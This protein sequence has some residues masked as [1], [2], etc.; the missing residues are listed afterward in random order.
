MRLWQRALGLACSRG[1]VLSGQR[2]L[3]AACARGRVRSGPR[4]FGAACSRGSVFS[5]QHA[6]GVAS[7][8]AKCFQG[9]VFSERWAL[10]SFALVSLALRSLALGA[11]SSR[12]C[13]PAVRRARRVCFLGSL[14][15]GH[16]VLGVAFY[17]A[18]ACSRSSVL[19]MQCFRRRVL[20]GQRA[21]GA[22]CSRSSPCS[23]SS[24]L[25]EEGACGTACCRRT[26]PVD[27][28]G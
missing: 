20:V 28:S 6:L 15:A 17:L 8:R 21:V 9:N 5:M 4:A 2:A 19:P 12:G 1:S 16:S 3:E 27:S 14:L 25:P 11:A 24:L 10:G 18:A 26:A 22:A 7:S 23:R 13:M